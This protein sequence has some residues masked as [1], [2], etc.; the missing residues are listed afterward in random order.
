MTDE[1]K[2]E[3]L[4]RLGGYIRMKNKS[5]ISLIAAASGSSVQP[6]DPVYTGS[7]AVYRYWTGKTLMNSMA[8]FNK[9]LAIYFPCARFKTTAFRRPAFNMT[10]DKA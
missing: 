1:N 3:K 8:N 4:C 9:E 7:G 2:Y 5:H 6:V 10:M